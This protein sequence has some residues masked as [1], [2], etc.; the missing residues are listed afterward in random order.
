MITGL[1]KYCR[2]PIE[3]GFLC[4]MADAIALRSND[5]CFLY[6]GPRQ[7]VRIAGLA[8]EMDFCATYGIVVP[9]PVQVEERVPMGRIAIELDGH[10]FHER[11]KEQAS[12][13]RSRD[14]AFSI[15]GFAVVRFT[16]AEV[17]S[18]AS[19][20]VSEVLDLV[21]AWSGVTMPSAVAR[22]TAANGTVVL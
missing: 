14:R 16:G 9:H 8:Y 19:S 11:T 12:R 15:A 6:V 17:Y 21:D 4:A 1:E 2:S 10:E 22:V 5:G 13:D 20:C 18:D 3:V 7:T